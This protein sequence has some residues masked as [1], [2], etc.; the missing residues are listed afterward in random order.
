MKMSYSLTKITER[1]RVR[2]FAIQSAMQFCMRGIFAIVLLLTTV[3]SAAFAQSTKV[4]GRVTDATD[5]EGIPFASVFFVGTTI[6]VSTDL[7]GYFTLETRDTAVSVLRAAMLSYESCDIP[8][9]RGAFQ[10]LNFVLKPE[11]NMLQQIVVKP[12]NRYIRHI[13]KQIEK[14]KRLHNPENREHYD[15]DIYNKMELDLT[16]ADERINNKLLRK[17]FGFVFNYMD[18]SVVSGQPYLPI[19]ISETS[20]HFYRRNNPS[21]SKE[22]IMASK[23]SGVN[24][25]S[26]FAQ[27]TGNMH[28]RTN[29]YDDFIRIFDVMIPS[30]VSGPNVFYDYY[31]IDSLDISGRKTYKIRFHP[32]KMISSPAFDGEMNVDAEDFAIREIHAKLRKGSNVNWIRDL[33]LDAEYDRL[34]NDIWFY[35]QDRLYADFSA[36]M[37]D[38]SKM[39]SF[40]GHRQIDYMNPRFDRPM[41]DSVS[42]MLV[43]VASMPDVLG[44]D[45]SYWDK[46]RPY[47]LTEKESNIYKMVD[48][49]KS[50]PLYKSIYTVVNTFING[51]YE[52]DRIGFGPYFKLF[53]FNDLE[54]ARFQFG[55]RTN[56]GFSKKLR[57]MAYAAYGTKDRAVKGGATVEYM[58][59]NQPTR[60][61]LFSA[62]RDVLQLGRSSGSLAEANI[63][64]SI[65]A[66][67]NSSKLSPVNDYSVS[68]QHELNENVNLGIA[69]ESRRVFSNSYVPMFTPDSAH[70]N[71]VGATQLHLSARFSWQETVTRG[72]FDKYYVQSKFPVLTFDVIGA[73]KSSNNDYS[74]LRMESTV[75]YRLQLP[76]AGI[77]RIE[78]SGGRI[79]G[80]VPYPF[81]KL[82]EGNGTFFFDPNSF[83]CMDFYEFASDTWVTMFYEH[84]FKG[85]FLGK[86]PLMKRLQWRE[87]FTLKTAYG[88]LS[89]GNN[90][91]TD[92]KIGNPESTIP[93]TGEEAMY[94]GMESEILFPD[95]MGSLKRPYVEMGVGVSN[96]F[97]VF[98]VDCFWRM[99]HRHKTIHGVRMKADHRVAVNFG[100]EFRF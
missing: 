47:A 71:S 19:M 52:R 72:N 41:P 50:V 77:S 90:G 94:E 58:F 80:K 3:S 35:K 27:F 68:Y 30:P 9:K 55:A 69:I 56:S 33:V 24:D 53:S 93:G 82:H 62:K 17:N 60:K 54:G 46:V 63:M 70:V 99:T 14:G 16:N 88:T 84:N 65:L 66:K 64:S 11:R 34:E 21:A 37:R 7:D 18:T 23:I 57:L 29:F 98:R 20:S 73:V 49:I 87:V 22:I 4:K 31:L 38:S 95:G 5:G 13:L 28:V 6:G 40:L 8:V 83:A 91:I 26:T 89:K 44:K 15:C 10:E 61:L 39:I 96:I 42:R 81:L 67:N 45:D 2:G 43:N 97:R 79:I 86:I 1:F 85:F 78:V 36:T 100:V 32:A 51:Y 75:Q 12:D 25:E 76:P 74:Y 92:G 48:S 59:G